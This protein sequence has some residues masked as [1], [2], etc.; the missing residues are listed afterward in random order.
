MPEFG[1]LLFSYYS[2]F[3]SI[4]MRKTSIEA[5]RICENEFFVIDKLLLSDAAKKSSSFWLMRRIIAWLNG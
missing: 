2:L 5:L 4:G 1:A 3:L